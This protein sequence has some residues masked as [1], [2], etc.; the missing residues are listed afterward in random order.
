MM[1]F[2]R[3]MGGRRLRFAGR[4]D[5]ATGGVRGIGSSPAPPNVY[6]HLAIT[7]SISA[8]WTSSVPSIGSWLD[9]QYSLP[10]SSRS[11]RAFP[12]VRNLMVSPHVL[13]HGQSLLREDSTKESKYAGLAWR[14]VL[15]PVAFVPGLIDLKRDWEFRNAGLF[16]ACHSPTLIQFRSQPCVSLTL[17]RRNERQCWSNGLMRNRRGASAE[18]FGPDRCRSRFLYCSRWQLLPC[19]ADPSHPFSVG[20]TTGQRP[21]NVCNTVAMHGITLVAAYQPDSHRGWSLVLASNSD[22]VPLYLMTSA[23]DGDRFA[24]RRFGY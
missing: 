6:F 11:D 12:R 9:H 24:T 1:H 4:H 18:T 15:P 8:K 10:D 2:A 23:Q 16:V 7:A 3:P 22:L 14:G 20:S 21:L 13:T 17:H 19:R 5:E